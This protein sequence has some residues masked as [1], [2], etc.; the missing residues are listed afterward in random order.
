MKE[1]G[2]YFELEL[3]LP[4]FSQIP[5][6]VMVNSG[7]HALEYILRSFG[8]SVRRVWLPYYT[9]DV[10]L[11]PIK[12]L[13]LDYM[14]YHV[15]EN[16]E[17]AEYPE[18]TD[19]DY[20][21]V[22]NYFGIK[23]KYISEMAHRYGERLIVD[24][25]QAWYCK[26]SHK[27]NYIYS[28]RKFFGLPDGGIAIG[29][30]NY[31]TTLPKGYSASRCSHLLRRIDEGAAAGYDNFRANSMTL[32]EEPLTRMSHLTSRLLATIDFER[33]KNKRRLNFEILQESLVK[34]NQLIIPPI[35]EFACAMV[36]PYMTSNPSLRSKLIANKIFVATYWPNVLNWCNPTS[37]EYRF[38]E[39]MIPLPI[40]QRY[41]QKDIK[42]IIHVINKFI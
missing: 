8:G 35:N 38:S 37:M 16:L 42:S 3:P 14:F 7:R 26:P 27:V 32:H 40:D 15:N 9:C 39:E 22:N 31:S 41:D 33:V 17:L 6:G 12:R 1:I 13:G 20:I 36:Y 21:I 2:G 4:D 25:A 29:T 28:P 23:D 5:E 10:V 19:G 30:F 34:T 11:Q 18:L 24:N